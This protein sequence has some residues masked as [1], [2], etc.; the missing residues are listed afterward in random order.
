M[1]S[2]RER[3]EDIPLLVAYLVQRYASKMGKKINGID[4]KT[5]ELFQAYHWPGNVRELQNVVERAVILCEGGTFAVQRIRAHRQGHR[6]S[7]TLL[8]PRRRA[9]DS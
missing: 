3:V 2:L 7:G 4:K 8:A 6:P 1:P 9:V 5:L